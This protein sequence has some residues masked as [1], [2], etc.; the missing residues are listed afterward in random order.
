MTSHSPSSA[1]PATVIL[2]PHFDDAALSLAGLIPA[3]PSPVCV[4]TVHGGAPAPGHEISWWDRTCGFSSA[5]E[6]HL[7]RLAED[8]RACAL[9]GVDH[10]VL[11]HPD[12]PYGD[13]GALHEIDTYLSDLPAETRVL[14]PLGTNQPDHAKVRDR[15]LLIL[16]KLG[17]PLPLVYADLPYTG[18]TARWAAPDVEVS[19]A[20][21]RDF[22]LSYQEIVSRYRTRPAY[23][24]ILTDQEWARKRAAVLA[25]ASQLAPLAVDH[26]A[27]LARGGPLCAERVWSLAEPAPLDEP[28]PP[29]TAPAPEAGA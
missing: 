29:E 6:A 26:G 27:L 3:L 16:D 24:R 19:L 14:V 28:G 2:S 5:G 12:G 25:Y 11:N 21:D 13:G 7:A 17:R 23:E 9:L 8:A 4:V 18:H 10:V 22:G 20:Q 1:P 15:A